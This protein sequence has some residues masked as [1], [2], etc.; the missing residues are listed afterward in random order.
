MASP[1]RAEIEDQL[2]KLIK[3]Y[4]EFRKF[5]GTHVA[6]G[7]SVNVGDNYLNMENTIITALETNFLSEWGAGLGNLRA[8][9]NA[10][11]STF[12][13]ASVAGFREFGKFI[14][15]TETDIPTILRRLYQYFVDNT[16]RVTS[17][18]FTFATPAALTGTGNGVL[19]RLN[20][21]E[22]NFDIE[23]Q[24]PDT[25]YVECIADEHSGGTE[26]EEI[27][28][29]RGSAPERDALKV[30]GSGKLINI[31]AKSARDSFD[32]IDNPSFSQY[33]GT[34]AVPTAITNWTV[35]T[36]ISNFLIDTTNYYRDYP[37]DTTPASVRYLANDTLTQN[38]NVRAAS[39]DPFRP[40]YLQIAWNR[41]I[42]AGDGTITLTFGSKTT[43]VVLAAQ[44]GWQILRMPIGQDNWHSRWNQ[45]NPT[46]AVQLSGRTT[47]YVL[48][49]DVVITPYDNFDG[50]WYAM[51]GG[52]TNFLR[53]DK[54][55][56]TDTATESIIQY[57][58]WLFWNA[59]LPHTTGGS[60]TW[61][62]P[63]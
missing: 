17:R 13:D 61:A 8:A 51:V 5:A 3:I 31:R 55:N 48:I 12:A 9:M 32:F 36:L 53:K 33:S 2:A 29:L 7:S 47:G 10:P 34:A 16:L 39:F 56:W 22:N 58:L 27:F 37:G 23:A 18:V 42:G 46:I 50:S 63:T 62:E 11:L 45:E 20:K 43:T 44:A 60:V 24:T 54:T 28:E 49:D 14:A 25:K 15:A 57:F 59:Y 40:Y 1:T 35:T 6:A 4:S 21:D 52:S 26:H 38:F 30:V 19:N 41:S